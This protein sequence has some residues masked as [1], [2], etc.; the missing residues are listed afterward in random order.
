MAFLFNAL[1]TPLL[2]GGSYGLQCRLVSSKTAFLI[3]IVDLYF[4]IETAYYKRNHK[5][6]TI[7]GVTIL[8]CPTT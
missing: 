8:T 1:T 5:W 7:Y 6:T 2:N 3:R 4:S